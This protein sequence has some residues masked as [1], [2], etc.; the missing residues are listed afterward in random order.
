[1]MDAEIVSRRSSLKITKS[2][3]IAANYDY[4]MVFKL[5]TDQTTGKLRQSNTAKYCVNKMKEKGLETFNY[6]SVQRD[7]LIVLIRCP[8]SSILKYLVIFCYCFSLSYCLFSQ[9]S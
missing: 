7:E 9:E 5:K 2:S 6:L 1:M 8:V 3:D 4:C